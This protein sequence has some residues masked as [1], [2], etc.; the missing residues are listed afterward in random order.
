MYLIG[1]EQFFRANPSPAK[2]TLLKP[3]SPSFPLRSE[4][5][6][7]EPTL[8][9][10]YMEMMTFFQVEEQQ[11]LTSALNLVSIRMK[12]PTAHVHDYHYR[13][14]YLKHHP[15]LNKSNPQ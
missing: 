3:G 15:K 4:V 7:G 14:D 1:S 13:N 12:C 9:E 8:L 11:S 5:L 6:P 10:I 2:V